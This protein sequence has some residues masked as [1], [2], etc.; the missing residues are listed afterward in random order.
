[1]ASS[2]PV[3]KREML[4]HFLAAL[5][6]RTQKALREAPAEFAGFSAGNQTRTPKELVRHM[7]SVL[8]YART[9]FV[10]GSYRAQPLETLED[11][12]IRFH[13][14]VEDLANYL[15]SETPLIGVTEEQL[16]QGPLSD[17]MTHAGQLAMLRRLAGVPVAPENFVFAGIHRHRL[18][19]DQPSPAAPDTIWPE[20]LAGDVPAKSISTT[21]PS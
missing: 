18:G 12:I 19:P 3:L 9:F 14:L 2:A 11:E 6:Y 20:R 16:L 5:A 21:L 7:S 1:M 17:A 13:S 8:G 4:R 15:D 10:G